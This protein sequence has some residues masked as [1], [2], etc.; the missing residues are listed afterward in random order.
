L[1]TQKAGAISV[2]IYNN[3]FDLLEY[4][5]KDNVIK[6]PSVDIE[7]SLGERIAK[8]LQVDPIKLDF[9]QGMSEFESSEG[10]HITDFSPW[11]PGLCTE[12]KP[13]IGALDG[14]IY[15]IY[16]MTKDNYATMI[17]TSMATPYTAASAALYL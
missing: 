12:I 10:G 5:A 2:I 17:G 6:I 14:H 3:V 15:S 9:S 11:E 16:H 7:Q 1:K 4:E 13:Y 8:L